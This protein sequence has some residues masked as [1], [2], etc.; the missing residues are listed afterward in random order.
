M[1]I[2]FVVVL[3]F[4]SRVNTK[5]KSLYTNT[6]EIRDLYKLNSLLR[7]IFQK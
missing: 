7:V 1:K 6:F 2:R 4:A 5:E 3:L